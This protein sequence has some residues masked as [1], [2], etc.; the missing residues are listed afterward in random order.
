MLHSRLMSLGEP[1]DDPRISK[2]LYRRDSS[3][4]PMC[5]PRLE[6]LGKLVIDDSG[7]YRDFDEELT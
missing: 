5:I 3:L 6:L 2:T 1:K 4:T 7:N